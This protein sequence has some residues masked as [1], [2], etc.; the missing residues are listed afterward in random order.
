MHP[1]HPSAAAIVAGVAAGILESVFGTGPGP[2]TI[3]DHANPNLKRPFGSVAQM[4]E[5]PREVRVWG[6]IHHRARWSSARRWAG[7]W[8]LT[9]RPNTRRP[10]G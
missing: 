7:G 4:A 9:C 3:T 5:K 10:A 6:G 2:F 8:S 1:E